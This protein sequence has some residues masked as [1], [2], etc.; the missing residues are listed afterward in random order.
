MSEIQELTDKI[1]KFRNDRD[2]QKFH[3]YKDM[4]LGLSLEASEV[5]EH[6]QW[7]NQEEAEEY[8]KTHKEDLADELSDVLYWVL[9]MS[10]D[11]GI[12]LK[13]ALPR[14]LRKN[15]LKYPLDKAKG[16]NVKYTQL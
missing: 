5:M 15:E 7:K 8:L 1:L 11:L 4:A 12:D 2:W 3:N 10:H 9:L 16:K 13:E 6:F 14:K